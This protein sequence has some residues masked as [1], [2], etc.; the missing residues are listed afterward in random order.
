MIIKSLKYLLIAGINASVLTFLLALWTD[1]VELIFN[2]Y[3]RPVEFLKI[4]G[5]TF[6]SLMSMRILVGFLNKKQ[7][8]DLKRK[9]IF[10]S[11][12]LTLTISA[13]FY[14]NYIFNIANQ[15]SDEIRQSLN[16]KIIDTLRYVNGKKAD[17][18]TS[19]E[20]ELLTKL[21]WFPKLPETAE[22]ISFLYTYEGFLPDYSFQLTYEVSLDTNI[23]E[24]EVGEGQFFM[25]QK[26]EFK[27]D[28]KIVIYEEGRW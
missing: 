3:V 6:F 26:V 5:L 19:K 15:Q 9:K 7:P 10:Y 16:E 13:Y 23:D 2:S 27:G 1:K 25:S 28:R 20:Y 4:I 22:K 11:S 12:I 8:G 21:S 14:I 17:N 18:I 24:I